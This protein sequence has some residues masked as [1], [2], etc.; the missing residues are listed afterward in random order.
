MF[1]FNPQKSRLHEPAG[2]GVTCNWA[3]CKPAASNSVRMESQLHKLRPPGMQP[4]RLPLLQSASSRPPR[5][6]SPAT[7]SNRSPTACLPAGLLLPACRTTGS[8]C[9]TTAACLLDYCCLAIVAL[10]GRLDVIYLD[11]LVTPVP[12]PGLASCQASQAV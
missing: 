6:T 10:P 3:Q 9:R 2:G 5:W 8:A 1:L 4:Y 11:C 12:R 7:P